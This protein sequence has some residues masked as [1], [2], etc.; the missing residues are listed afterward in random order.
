MPTSIDRQ[1][2]AYFRATK[3]SPDRDDDDQITSSAILLIL[4]GLT[5]LAAVACTLVGLT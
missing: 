5:C 3:P 4:A 2:D 1:F